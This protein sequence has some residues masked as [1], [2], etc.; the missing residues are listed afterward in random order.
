MKNVH[1]FGIIGILLVYFIISKSKK[2][3]VKN[4]PFAVLEKSFI[5]RIGADKAKF[6]MAQIKHE[7]G[8]KINDLARLN[9]YSGITFVGQKYAEDSHIKQPDGKLNYASYKTPAHYIEDYLRIVG[10]SIKNASTLEDYARNLKRQ[11]YY[12]DTLQNYT[13][14]LAY[15]YKKSANV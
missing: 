6:A 13:R 3:A 9:N 15:W 11:N 14:G 2:M 4:N 10:D 8:G 1:I 7:L 12:G 5:E